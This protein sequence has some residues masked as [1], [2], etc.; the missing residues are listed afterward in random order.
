MATHFQEPYLCCR[1]CGPGSWPFRPWTLGQSFSCIDRN[2]LRTRALCGCCTQWYGELVDRIIQ[3]KSTV[4]LI[5]FSPAYH[6]SNQLVAFLAQLVFSHV[7]SLPKWCLFLGPPWIFTCPA[8]CFENC[9]LFTSSLHLRLIVYHKCCF[10]NFLRHVTAKNY[11]I[12][13]MTNKDSNE[14]F[15]LLMLLLREGN[16]R[17]HYFWKCRIV[18]PLYSTVMIKLF[19]FECRFI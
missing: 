5:I 7:I 18:K 2:K 12:W 10:V 11:W 9:I 8:P 16:E 15:D 19:S 1:H 13:F 6:S 4:L 3:W 14:N 17:G